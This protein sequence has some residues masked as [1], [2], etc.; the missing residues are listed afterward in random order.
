MADKHYDLPDGKKILIG[1]ERFRCTEAFFE[2]ELCGH[3][4][5]S[6][7]IHQLCYDSII[8]SHDGKDERRD[9]FNNIILAGGN[10][11]FE[12]MPER[13][14]AEMTKMAGKAG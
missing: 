8:E 1:N 10:T 4:A 13:M 14:Q 3:E 9:F 5:K 12:G 11:L 7:G 6:K 2:P